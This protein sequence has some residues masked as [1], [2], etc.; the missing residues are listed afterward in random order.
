VIRDPGG[1][2]RRDSQRLVNPTEI[3]EGEP[4]R[5]GCPVVLKLLTESIREPGE[6]ADAHSHGKVLPLDMAGA[7][8]LRIGLAYAHHRLR[9]DHL[10]R[11]VAPFAFRCRTVDFDELG[12]VHTVI[13]G[14]ADRRAVGSEAVRGDLEALT[15]SCQPQTFDESVSRALIA[16]THR[17]VQNQLGVALNR[18]ERVAIPEA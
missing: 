16:L 3:V 13:K 14:V 9:G 17:E 6:A 1:H 2:S 7:D 8:S 4:H 5:D 11:G 10:C 18:D 12:E 15:R